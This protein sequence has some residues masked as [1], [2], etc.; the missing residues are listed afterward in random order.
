M[1]ASGAAYGPESSCVLSTLSDV[2]GQRLSKAAAFKAQPRR[3]IFIHS[4]NNAKITFACIHKKCYLHTYDQE[5]E[6][7]TFSVTQC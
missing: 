6:M 7:S 4:D 1:C 5:A 2:T 3:V